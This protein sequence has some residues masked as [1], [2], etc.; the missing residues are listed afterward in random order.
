MMWKLVAICCLA[1]VGETLA[2]NI[3][4]LNTCIQSTLGALGDKRGSSFEYTESEIKAKCSN[5]KEAQVCLDTTLTECLSNLPGSFNRDSYES[6]LDSLA[7]LC[8][9]AELSAKYVKHAQCMKEQKEDLKKCYKTEYN[10]EGTN[11]KAA[12]KEGCCVFYGQVRC[13][14]DLFKDKC[15][16][17]AGEFAS[18]YLE[19]VAGKEITDKCSPYKDE[20]SA[21]TANMA[22]I[23]LIVTSLLMALLIKK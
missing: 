5:L 15:G 12:I 19:D 22:S 21:S 16:N 6:I 18:E 1:L 13:S 4:K 17:E 3:I 2:C 7:P 20:C 8:K 23:V 10:L 14:T 9:N 11:D